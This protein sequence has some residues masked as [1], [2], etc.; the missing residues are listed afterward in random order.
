VAFSPDG[1]IVASAAIDETVQLWK[2]PSGTPIGVPLSN[3]GDRVAFS[4][5]GKILATGAHN[6]KVRLWEVPTGKSIRQFGTG[7]SKWTYGVAFSP[8]GKILASS[9]DTVRLWEVPT[10]K[11]IGELP[12][13]LGWPVAFSPDGKVL[14]SAR[15]SGTVQLSE[16]PTGTPISELL[17]GN[18]FGVSSVAFSPDGKTLA[19]GYG[20]G[21]V[22]LWPN[23]ME[24]WIQRACNQAERNLTQSEWSQYMGGTAYVRTCPDLPSGYS[25]PANAPAARYHD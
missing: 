19:S 3:A 14:A 13:A 7:S 23:G 11:P 16:V 1:K 10:G 17:T 2:F 22:R 12:T 5:N 8:D 20:D 9:N 18:T 4:P 6:G 21:T 15:R 25:A 24:T